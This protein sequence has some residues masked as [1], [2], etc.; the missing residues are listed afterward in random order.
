MVGVGRPQC[1]LHQPGSQPGG[2]HAF[3][4][5]AAPDPYRRRRPPVGRHPGCHQPGSRTGLTT[6]HRLIPYRPRR[7]SR[8]GKLAMR[9]RD[10]GPELGVRYL[11]GLRRRGGRPEPYSAPCP[12]D[13]D[14]LRQR[15][16]IDR[17]LEPE[18]PGS[19]GDVPS[20]IRRRTRIGLAI[21]YQS[22]QAASEPADRHDLHRTGHALEFDR[23]MFPELERPP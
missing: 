3:S 21:A 4:V 22:A 16:H 12:M 19:R 1:F 5:S 11:P 2:S 14:P 10:H 6:A 8:A 15:H 18:P 23:P 9:V 17:S 7:G 20:R 13:R